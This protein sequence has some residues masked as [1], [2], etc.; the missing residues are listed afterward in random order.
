[1][2]TVESNFHRLVHCRKFNRTCSQALFGRL[3]PASFPQRDVRTTLNYSLF[4]VKHFFRSLGPTL[5]SAA[6]C[7]RDKGL[8]R[9]CSEELFLRLGPAFSQQQHVRSLQAALFRFWKAPDTY[10]DQIVN[11]LLIFSRSPISR[12]LRVSLRLPAFTQPLRN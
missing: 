5:L 7:P 11:F 9:I 1:M 6:G 2:E 4:A 3:G 12:A 8:K 10:R